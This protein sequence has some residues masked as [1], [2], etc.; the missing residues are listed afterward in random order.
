MKNSSVEC[1]N[2]QVRFVRGRS[3]EISMTRSPRSTGSVMFKPLG[4]YTSSFCI[5]MYADTFRRHWNE[6]KLLNDRGTLRIWRTHFLVMCLGKQIDEIGG[7]AS[8]EAFAER[9][10]IS[11]LSFYEVFVD[12][13]HG[14]LEC[15]SIDPCLELSWKSVLELH[16]SAW[17]VFFNQISQVLD[18]L[19]R[20]LT[21]RVISLYKYFRVIWLQRGLCHPK[22]LILSLKVLQNIFLFLDWMSLAAV[23]LD[24]A[25]HR[26][27]C[28]GSSIRHRCMLREICFGILR[29][30]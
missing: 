30:I 17:N 23:Q 21:L 20:F 8:T 25:K 26:E 5:A 13:A 11:F 24:N 2:G 3:M 1:D 16:R 19:R 10:A 9:A 22:Q 18:E 28:G 6:W 14:A 7:E 12:L 15:G 27:S 4:L 29:R